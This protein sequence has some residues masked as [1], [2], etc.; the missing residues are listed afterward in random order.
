MKSAMGFPFSMLAAGLAVTT[1]A[2]DAAELLSLD[3]QVRPSLRAFVNDGQQ[4]V[5]DSTTFQ[6]DFDADRAT[7]R[8]GIF[9]SDT[10][11]AEVNLG[12]SFGMVQATTTVEASEQHFEFRQY[13]SASGS[14]ATNDL[15]QI[16]FF[17][18]ASFDIRF[19]TPTPVDITI[20]LA[21]IDPPID[22]RLT[23][24]VFL[25]ENAGTELRYD[26]GDFGSV[27]EFSVRTTID[28]LEYVS[29][30]FNSLVSFALVD[31]FPSATLGGL[32]LYGS[33]TVVPAPGATLCLSA[34]GLLA[35][36]R[37]R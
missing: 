12:Q 9:W 20:R 29:M 2:V 32:E 6:M 19:D 8:D 22:Q 28:P 17:D 14:I 25:A 23:A 18:R 13:I 27:Q 36:R 5:E 21:T 35:A 11:I 33:V 10:S 31:G 30:D 16:D 37:R 24:Q 3:G 4:P 34:F 26:A 7:L 15:M 1:A